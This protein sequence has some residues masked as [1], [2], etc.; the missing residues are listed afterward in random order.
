MPSNQLCQ[1]F[2]LREVENKSFPVCFPNEVGKDPIIQFEDKLP[3]HSKQ[4]WWKTMEQRRA[5]SDVMMCT[6]FHITFRTSTAEAL[7]HACSCGNIAAAPV[8][9]R[10]VNVSQNLEYTAWHVERIRTNSHIVIS[11]CLFSTVFAVRFCRTG[12]IL[13]TG[14]WFGSFG[15]RWGRHVEL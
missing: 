2:F 13:M 4:D 6:F 9:L 10:S 15:A 14:R 7:I 12:G 11:P 1:L 3:E 8:L 5:S